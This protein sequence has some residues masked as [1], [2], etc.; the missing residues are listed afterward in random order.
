[1]ARGRKYYQG[2]FK[3]KHPEKYAGD[4]NKIVFRSGLEKRYFKKIDENPDII[5][6]ASEEAECIIP[7]IS[8]LDGRYHRYFC[9]VLIKTKNGEVFLIE[10][11]PEAETREPQKKGRKSQQTFMQEVLT[12]SVNSAKWKA[13]EAHCKKKKWKF[14]ILTENQI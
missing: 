5:K 2:L 6:W 7:Y 9:D 10:I 12:W 1:M 13:A 14:L 11:K 3:P 4:P 8:P